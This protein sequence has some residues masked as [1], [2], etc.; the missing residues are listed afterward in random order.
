MLIVMIIDGVFQSCFFKRERARLRMSGAEIDADVVRVD[1]IRRSREGITV[2]V[3][4][5]G[6]GTKGPLLVHL[7]ENQW[8]KAIIDKYNSDPRYI[9]RL[10]ILTS[11]TD[12]HMMNAET[13]LQMLEQW[14]K[15]V[16]SLF[17][18][19]RIDIFTSCCFRE[20]L[21]SNLPI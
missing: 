17:P 1:P 13:T 2:V 16:P 3:S 14:L 21:H 5:F 20:I 19:T 9:G 4:T 18:T 10:R 15:P 7:K 11:G 8:P 12:T 6:N